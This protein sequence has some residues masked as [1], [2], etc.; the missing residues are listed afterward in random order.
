MKKNIMFDDLIKMLISKKINIQTVYDIGANDGVWTR[1]YEKFLPNAIFYMF[2]ANP[3]KKKP[4]DVNIKHR[5][6]NAVLSDSVKTIDFYY[7]NGT[8]DSYYKEMT[9]SYE[10]CNTIKLITKTL[11]EFDYPTPDIIKIDTQGSEIDIINGANKIF[12]KCKI[13]QIEMPILP[14]NKNAPTF[15]VYINTLRDLDLFPVGLN[16][17]HYI[18]GILIQIDLVFINKNIRKILFNEIKKYKAL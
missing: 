10:N 7:V 5:W 11:A 1:T 12:E 14:Y 17:L 2:E 18:D 6:E 16:E 9:T 15:D 13:L 3:N 4:M 8:G